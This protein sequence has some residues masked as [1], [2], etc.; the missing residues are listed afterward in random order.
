MA[1]AL[2]RMRA[3]VTAGASFYSATLKHPTSS[4]RSIPE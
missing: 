1:A 2:E 3:D 4:R